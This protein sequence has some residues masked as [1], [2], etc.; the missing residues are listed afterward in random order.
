MTVE[1]LNSYG[2]RVNNMTIFKYKDIVKSSE[3]KIGTV[4]ITI[5]GAL[6]LYL[7]KS[8][9]GEL[10]FYWITSIGVMKN[11]DNTMF[12]IVNEEIIMPHIESICSTITNFRINKDS[13]KKL[14]TMPAIAG[15]IYDI[16]NIKQW[17]IKNNLIGNNIKEVSH[18]VISSEVNQEYKPVPAEELEIGK[19][20][21][22][23]KSTLGT[24]NEGYRSSWIYLG[25]TARGYKYNFIGHLE[26]FRNKDASIIEIKKD[27]EIYED[28]IEITK[29]PKKLYRPVFYK[30]A[31]D[32]KMKV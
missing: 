13:I 1:I 19:I 5:N 15:S 10:I 11:D 12:M 25:K 16:P 2:E 9:K 17:I 26:P 8:A 6:Y 23:S 27:L 18:G 7:G 24:R 4:Y 22:G 31:L 32:F 30:R 20:Y 29:T 3:L 14:N 28:N 21:V